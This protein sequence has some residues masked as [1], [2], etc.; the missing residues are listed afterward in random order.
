MKLHDLETAKNHLCERNLTLSIIKNGKV[1][2]E[3]ASHGISGLLEAI[4]K[5]R[6]KLEGASVAD[7]VAGKVIALLC[8]YGKVKAVYATTL[9]QEAKKVLEENAVYLEWRDLVDNVLNTD[10]TGICAFEKLTNAI[11]NPHEAYEKLNALKK[12]LNAPQ[13]KIN[14]P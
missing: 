11:S 13:M 9:S 14:E 3:T 5:C 12:S 7:K 2:C 4:E 6:N 1:V 10:K 8:V